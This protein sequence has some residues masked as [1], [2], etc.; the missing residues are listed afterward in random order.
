MRENTEAL[1]A[2][3]TV[4]RQRRSRTITLLAE[5]L[6]KEGRADLGLGVSK[7]LPEQRDESG[8]DFLFIG[9]RYAA[10]MGKE[11]LSYVASPYWPLFPFSIQPNV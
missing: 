10:V 5:L 11:S 9:E 4:T 3:E 1:E 8:S 2:R 6:G 7:A